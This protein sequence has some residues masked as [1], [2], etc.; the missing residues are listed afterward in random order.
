MMI[1]NFLT[2]LILIIKKTFLTR[3]KVQMIN[4]NILKVK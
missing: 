4:L 2:K 1:F 3:L